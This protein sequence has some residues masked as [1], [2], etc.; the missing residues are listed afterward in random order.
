MAKAPPSLRDLLG[1]SDADCDAMLRVAVECYG[2]GELAKA[3]TILVGV[4]QLAERDARPV[5]LLAS[6]LLLQ[7]KHRE[8]EA[9]YERAH[10]LDAADPYTLVALGEIKL[11]ALKIKEAIPL[12]ERLFDMD[13]DGKHPAAN[14]GRDVVKS[15][16][17]K[18]KGG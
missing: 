2:N 16:Y 17:A 5:K 1:F 7:E 11:K 13:P 3:E 6:T 4:M 14:R 9:L 8:A 15:F 10:A 12:F 18:M